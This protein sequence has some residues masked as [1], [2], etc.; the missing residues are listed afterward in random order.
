MDVPTGKSVDAG[1]LDPLHLIREVAESAVQKIQ[2]GGAS[3][4][5]DLLERAHSALS[6]TIEQAGRIIQMID[7]LR[8]LSQT[9]AGGGATASIHDSTHQVL[10]AMQ[11]EYPLANIT[12]LKILPHDLMPVPMSPEHLE[13]VLFQLFCHARQRVMEQKGAIITLEAA[14]KIYLTPENPSQ[15]RFALRLSNSGPEIDSRELPHLFDPFLSADKTG[16]GLYLVRKIVEHYKGV[17]Q[18]E[19]QGRGTS[20]YLEIPS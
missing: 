8:S 17:I 1:F 16:F 5:K 19:T 13:T 3:D 9:R 7:H 12:F 2:E 15:K 11:Y 18:V 20:F 6:E 10:H 4:A 14:E